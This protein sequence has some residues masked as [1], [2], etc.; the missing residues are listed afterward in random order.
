MKLL[1]TIYLQS[2]LSKLT[3]N[4]KFFL[5][6]IFSFLLSIFICISS[7]LFLV[8]GGVSLNNIYSTRVAY[9]I[10]VAQIVFGVIGIIMLG[11][12]MALFVLCIIFIIRN[13]SYNNA[14]YVNTTNN[15]VV[16]QNSNNTNYSTD[17]TNNGPITPV[18]SKQIDFST[19][20]ASTST[21][22]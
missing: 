2:I 16:V 22:I 18:F 20:S 1:P 15:T 21:S 4:E 3:M 17:N 10:G 9:D 13:N 5:I 11:F 6:G 7:F 12:L 14:G 19:S 8:F